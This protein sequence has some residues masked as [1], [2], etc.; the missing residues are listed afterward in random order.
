MYDTRTHT[1]SY[2]NKTASIS[3]LV[4]RNTNENV[5]ARPC[6]RMQKPDSMVENAV[7]P[8]AN[9]PASTLKSK[10]KKGKEERLKRV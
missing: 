5:Y 9:R 8:L 7:P 4:S 1:Y 6:Q 2:I 10:L 3:D